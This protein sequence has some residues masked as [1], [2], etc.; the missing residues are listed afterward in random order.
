[1][2]R[3]EGSRDLFEGVNSSHFRE[4]WGVKWSET[5]EE[6]EV[7][8]KGSENRLR[9]LRLTEQGE[10]VQTDCVRHEWSAGCQDRSLGRR[11][12]TARRTHT[13]VQQMQ[14]SRFSLG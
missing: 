11:R 7:R 13:H 9:I 8:L 14:M 10:K 3:E 2:E 6:R 1:M 4:S 5:L 12:R